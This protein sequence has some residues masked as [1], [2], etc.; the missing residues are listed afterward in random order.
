MIHIYEDGFICSV[1][2]FDRF[3]SLDA[4]VSQTITCLTR[5]QSIGLVLVAES[6][7]ISLISVLWVFVIIFR[8][9]RRHVRQNDEA[10]IWNMKLAPMD[11]FM[12]SLFS[13]DLVQALGAVMD[14]K[15]INDGKV[16]TGQFCTAQGVIQQ[17]GETGVAITT[18]VIAVWTFIGVWWRIDSGA[19]RVASFV[20]VIVWT[21]VILLVVITSV[22]HRDKSQL[23]EVPTPY[24]CWIGKH[25][26]GLRLG[27]EY[28]WLWI[29][30]GVSF[31]VYI[32]LFFW[33][34]GNISVDEDFWCRASFH[35]SKDVDEKERRA[36]FAMIAYPLI[37]SLLVL[38]LSIGRWISSPI[39]AAATLTVVAI[40]GLSGASN[41][42]LLLIT[43][44]SS[45]LFGHARPDYEGR[46]TGTR[47]PDM[48]GL[49][50]VHSHDGQLAAKGGINGTTSFDGNRGRVQ[51][52]HDYGRAPSPSPSLPSLSGHLTDNNG[53]GLIRD[54]AGNGAPLGRLPSV[55][56]DGH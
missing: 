49:H 21:F 26:T 30:L 14:I 13:A 37:Y 31:L 36:S 6:G 41:V 7:F 27:G 10:T 19:T 32:P 1:D 25:H 28:I 48:S 9:L 17:L 18:L 20:M 50:G 23:Y 35:R 44:P 47:A 39:S 2:D 12:L 5:G 42:L 15:W 11:I 54:G 3:T 16:E 40:Y 8:N 29:T 53:L 46:D 4:N 52:S 33:S 56:D 24:W 34:R 55:T 51:R 43:R 45:K 22:V 38:P